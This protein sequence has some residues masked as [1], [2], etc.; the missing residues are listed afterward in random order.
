MDIPEIYVPDDSI[1]IGSR[2]PIQ[3][4]DNI[5]VKSAWTGPCLCVCL[6]E[7]AGGFWPPQGVL[8]L[9]LLPVPVLEGGG[10]NDHP[11]SSAGLS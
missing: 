3:V 1:D 8:S 9:C 11:P 10:T 6:G 2:I 4:C 7:C 5:S